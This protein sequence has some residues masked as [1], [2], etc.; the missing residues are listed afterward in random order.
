MIFP[1]RK[2]LFKNELSYIMEKATEKQLHSFVIPYPFVENYLSEKIQVYKDDDNGLYYVIHQGK[3]LYY[4]RDY[5]TES[6]VREN[7]NYILIE[8]D[9]DSPHSY[10]S[11]CFTVNQNDT[12]FDIGAAEG[13]FSLDVVERVSSLYLFET[14][15]KWVEAL[16]ATFKPWEHKVHIINKYVCNSDSNTDISLNN[17]MGLHSVDFIKMDVEGAEVNILRD[18]QN[19][20]KENRGVKFAV[21][22]YHNHSDAKIIEHIFTEC[23]YKHTYSSGYMLFIHS[24]L[25]PPY[26][27]RG[28]IRAY[29]A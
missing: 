11:E 3:R 9:A 14:N 18:I 15:E 28:L 26:F 22:T 4:S 7:Y 13:N 6:A 1:K 21:C 25:R 2:K 27:R 29:P 24:K 23:G 17:F 19:L 10:I 8:Q 20:I 5:S 12:V 16:Q